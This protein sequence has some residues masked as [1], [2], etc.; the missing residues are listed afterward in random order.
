[1]KLAV[2][3]RLSADIKNVRLAAVI[4][5]RQPT[6]RNPALLRGGSRNK[7]SEQGSSPA[8]AGSE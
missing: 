6:E 8:T 2:S 7:E 1:M 5:I 4:P 3:I